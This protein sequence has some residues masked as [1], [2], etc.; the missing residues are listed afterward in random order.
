MRR[1]TGIPNK[2][3]SPTRHF[4]TRAPP[5]HLSFTVFLFLFQSVVPRN[6]SITGEDDKL[7][8]TC[9]WTELKGAQRGPVVDAERTRRFK[10]VEAARFFGTKPWVVETSKGLIH[11]V[12]FDTRFFTVHTLAR[13]RYRGKERVQGRRSVLCYLMRHPRLDAF[14]KPWRE[15]SCFSLTTLSGLPAPLCVEKFNRM[16]SNN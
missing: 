11:A 12:A 15:K 8:R 2:S 7:G 16:F 14:K 10:G 13:R 9:V 4:Q 3:S 5:P 6:E 1:V